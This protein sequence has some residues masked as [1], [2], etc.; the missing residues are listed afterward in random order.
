[1]TP[2]S[3]VHDAAAEGA[4]ALPLRTNRSLRAYWVGEAVTLAGPSVHG[5]A[6]PVIAVLI[7]APVLLGLRSALLPRST[8][9]PARHDG[10]A[11]GVG[12]WEWEV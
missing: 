6:L 2:T 9:I 8:R 10:R 1:V 3:T 12:T 11:A 4:A 7:T 5:V